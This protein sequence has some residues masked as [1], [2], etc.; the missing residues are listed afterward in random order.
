MPYVNRRRVQLTVTT[1]GGTSQAFY[2][3]GQLLYGLVESL[4]YTRATA[5]A[6]STN[7]K[8]IVTGEKSGITLWT[9]TA[10]GDVT[11]YPRV[12][13]QDVSGGGLY[14]STSVVA[15]SYQPVPIPLGDERLKV[16]ISSGGAASG[17]NGLK[18]T[19]DLYISGI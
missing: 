11:R 2:S 13:A 8:I 16:E 12:Q 5:S 15:I 9:A 17:G 6:I 3:T 10:T 7:A 1:T 19:L 4:V 14:F 18:A